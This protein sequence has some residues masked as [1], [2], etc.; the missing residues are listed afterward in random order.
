MYNYLVMLSVSRG[1]GLESWINN[2]SG[3]LGARVGV[4]M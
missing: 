4:E 1:M 3:V 2:M